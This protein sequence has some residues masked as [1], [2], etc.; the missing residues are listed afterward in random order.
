[1]SVIRTSHTQRLLLLA[2]ELAQE[3]DG[4]IPG[5]MVTTLEGQ[6]IWPGDAVTSEQMLARAANLAE[7]A[8]AE[9]RDEA[10]TSVGW[11]A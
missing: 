11:P 4:L 1:M 9:L 8:A 3:V 5:Q 10:F 7:H 6:R 2:L